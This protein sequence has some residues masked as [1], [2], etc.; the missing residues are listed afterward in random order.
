R[1]A[2]VALRAHEQADQVRSPRLAG[3]AADV[4]ERAVREQHFEREDVIGRDAV[5]EAVRSAGV[6]GH[7]PANRARALAGR[8]GG[9]LQA[10]RP[11][12]GAELRVHHAGLD[13]GQTVVAI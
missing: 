4:D 5:L 6:L 1:Y 3:R 13:D 7:V 8:I 12:G 9:V 10:V 11:G 2:E